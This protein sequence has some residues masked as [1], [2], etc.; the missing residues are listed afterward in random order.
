VI[1][2]LTVSISPAGRELL[3]VLI[4]LAVLFIVGVAGVV[5]FIRQW[6][7]ER[8]RSALK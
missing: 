6:R 8:R 5:I 1:A 3:F 4:L 2:L 7:K